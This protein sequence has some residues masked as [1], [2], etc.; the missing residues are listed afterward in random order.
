MLREGLAQE[1]SFL[2]YRHCERGAWKQPCKVR[3]N[4]WDTSTWLTEKWIS[5]V[6]FFQHR[7]VWQ[8]EDMEI[9][10]IRSRAGRQTSKQRPGVQTNHQQRSHPHNIRMR[11]R[12]ASRTTPFSGRRSKQQDKEWRVQF[13]EGQGYSHFPI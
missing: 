3:R 11:L 6:F 2:G 4:Q 9:T 7:R 5:L 10:K 8:K 12:E 13:H 1:E